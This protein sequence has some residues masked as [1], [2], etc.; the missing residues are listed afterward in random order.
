MFPNSRKSAINTSRIA[1]TAKISLKSVYSPAAQDEFV[2]LRRKCLKK[3][4]CGSLLTP[5]SNILALDSYTLQRAK[6]ILDS[7][8][9]TRTGKLKQ[10]NVRLMRAYIEENG[11]ELNMNNK[12][13][14]QINQGWRTAQNV[15]A[16]FSK[17]KSH[18][19]HV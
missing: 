5:A 12:R 6:A 11:R 7:R 14:E 4:P 18:A 1:S 2:Q 16:R 8:I 9:S 15:I 17:R 10:L 3:I 19:T 13:D